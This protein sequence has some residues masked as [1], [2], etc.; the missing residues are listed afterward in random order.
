[1]TVYDTKITSALNQSRQAVVALSC[2]IL[3]L[4]RPRAAPTGARQ[5]R[6]P[7]RKNFPFRVGAR[8]VPGSGPKRKMRSVS[9]NNHTGEIR[10]A[11]GRLLVRERA[12]PAA[13]SQ[14]QGQ[15]QVT[16]GSI[17]SCPALPRCR[18]SARSAFR[19]IPE[20]PQVHASYQESHPAVWHA[21]ALSF[22]PS[23]VQSRSI[24]AV[25][26]VH[27]GDSESSHRRRL[28]WQWVIRALGGR[29]QIAGCIAACQ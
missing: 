9:T 13:R 19:C 21:S 26:V 22:Q 24:R 3:R 20:Q 15:G 2:V 28:R 11:I 8:S 5:A 16:T 1:M 10:H 17:I 18:P 14:G 12:Q 6:T 27:V 25:D 7:A 29:L 4:V 23:R